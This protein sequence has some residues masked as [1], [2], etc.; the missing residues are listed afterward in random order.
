MEVYAYQPKHGKDVHTS[1]IA[2]F[3]RRAMFPRTYSLRS[4]LIRILFISTLAPLIILGSISYFSMF[5]ILKNKAEGGVRSNLHQVR[6]SLEDTLSQLNHTSQQLAFDGRVG[7]NLENYLAADLYEK[8][9]LGDEIHS[10]LSLIHFTN[11]TLGLMFYY[12]GKEHQSLFE[13]YSIGNNIENLK[14]LPVLFHFDKIRYFGPHLSLNPIDGHIVLSILRQVELPDRDDVYVYIETNFKLTENMI[15]NEQYGGSLIHLITDNNGEIVY[16]ENPKAF[17]TGSV[18]AEHLESD[19]SNPYYVFEE[20]SNQ[21]WKVMAA[22]PKSVY[23]SEINRWIQQFALFAVITLVASCFI[24][25]LIWRTVFRP[26]SHLNM[27]IRNVKNINERDELPAR[28][29]PINEFAVIHREFAAMRDRIGELISE[30]E[31]KEKGKAK[32]EVEKLMAQINPHFIHNTLDTIRWIARANGQKDIDRLVSTLNKVLHYNLGKGGPTRMK[33]EIEALKQY[34]E[35]QGIRYQFE[36]D[37]KVRADSEALELPVPRFILQPLVENALYHGLGDQG[38]IEVDVAQDHDTHV[39]ITVKDNG[40]GIPEEELA[41]MLDDSV[42]DRKK[43][44]LGIGLNYVNRMLKFQF[45]DDASFRIESESGA[46]T[47]VCLRLPIQYKE[48]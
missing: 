3:V 11:P 38:V 40:D 1:M 30:V 21:T 28:T 45:G 22:I 26:L 41:A 35:L 20:Q 47:T 24:A 13:N 36:F 8:K 2:S 33:D 19:R 23:R 27:D 39:I 34:V 25:W 16:S 18:V 43:V 15:K 10:E 12:F 44:G 17:P 37:V 5:A 31:Q 14:H 4:R 7:K 46:G 32:L 42:Q 9:R 48:A 6:I 29:S